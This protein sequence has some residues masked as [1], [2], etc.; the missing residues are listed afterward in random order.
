[1]R[2]KLTSKSVPNFLDLIIALGALQGCAVCITL[3][4]STSFD[5]RF[6]VGFVE[7]G[8][9]AGTGVGEGGD[10]MGNGGSWGDEGPAAN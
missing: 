6:L 4:G 2:L 7:P 10:G 9:G 3:A 8:M 1:M 5:L